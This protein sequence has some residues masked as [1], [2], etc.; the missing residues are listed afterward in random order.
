MLVLA[1]A[2]LAHP[3]QAQEP[4]PAEAPP[5]EGEELPILEM[6]QIAT[7]VEAAYPPEAEAA[8]IEGTVLLLV[9]IDETGAV[10]HVEVVQPIG[11]GFDEAALAA[12]QQMRFTPAMTAEGPVAVAFEFA[13]G[14]VLRPEAPAEAP[15]EAA[16]P[17]VNLEGSIREMGTRRWLEGAR[18]VVIGPEQ[19]EDLVAST[20][21]DGKFQI[22]GVPPGS[23]TLRVLNPG[24]VT[25]EQPIEVVEGEI[26]SANL[27][28]RAEEYRENEAVGVYRK[29]EQ[30][31]TRRTL[32]IE[33]VRR[34]PGTFGDPVKVI[35]TLPGAARSPFGTGLLII[36]GSNP[37][38]SGVYVDGVRIP[39]IYHITGTTSVLSPDLIEAVD[40]LPGGFG[41][42][43]GR[44]MGGVV[45]I[46]TKSEFDQDKIV[47]GTDILDSQIYFE[48]RLGKN[49]KHGFAVGAR[50]SY[51]DAFIPLFTADTGYVIKPRYWDY[52]VKWVPDLGAGRKFSTFVYG[53]N[54][55]LTVST[56]ED[57]A[58]GSDQDT[59]GDLF[60][61]YATH[62]LVVNFE[63]DLGN[64][65]QLRLTPS[66]G[67]DYADLGLGDEFRLKSTNL[68]PEL[69]AELPWKPSEAVEIVPGV[70]FIGGWWSFEF[71]SPFR[72][73]DVDDPLDERE[74]VF[75]DGHGTGWGPD[76]YIK[77]NLRPLE[78]RDKLLI[79]PG[80]R[81][82]L[83]RFT[84]KGSVTSDE[85]A[86]PYTIGAVD[87]RLLARWELVDNVVLKGS[88]GLYNQ[89][90]Q[91]SESIGVGTDV[92]T[93]FE[94]SWGSSIGIEHQLSQ[95]VH[96]D[97][98]LF[99]KQMD[100][101]IIFDE[102]WTGFGDAVFINEGA[103]RAWGTE[104]ILRH[105]K[106]KRF[107][108][109][110][111][112]TYS[113]SIRC[114]ASAEVCDEDGPDQQWYPFDF[115]QPH[116]FSAQGGYDLPLDFAVS[117]QVQYVSG[118]PDSVYNAGV[119]DADSDYYN[120][121]RIGE[122]NDER[123]PP[124]FQTS[125]RIDRLWTF[126]TWQ[127]A[128][129]VDLMNVVRGVNPE[130]TIYNYDYTDY[131][132]VRGLPFIPNIGIEARFY[133]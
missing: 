47:W 55:L 18:V 13:Y 60:T 84:Y 49:D 68:V 67:I 111:S 76:A 114:D 63:Q 30:E 58:Q 93:T 36:R 6:P 97:V 65:W 5:A 125:V 9:E 42:Q 16:P 40:Y 117:A 41:V 43:Y 127:L 44:S 46:R 103:G 53:F 106:T 19:P 12:A 113:R 29:D 110:V 37:E 118:N 124:F 14:F 8:G 54:D 74:N 57:V 126:R 89:P 11:N 22:R 99:Y 24:H 10:T 104:V 64:G 23:W 17:P 130:F 59:Q 62:R 3:V 101:L 51:I 31:V 81:T 120:P 82:N 73:G 25:L 15:T 91:P 26:T 88:T 56:P 35:Q 87:P 32:T 72:I 116:I 94:R 69:R 108:G 133:P 34:V 105:A 4:P 131:A 21:V 119:Y 128:T 95:A 85:G 27:W 33:E 129:Y 79:T 123:L 1:L 77:A 96:W 70:D 38:D 100:D 66:L 2:L 71:A 28:I 78:D 61:M 48:G 7:Y 92:V 107:F 132:Y 45:D 90:P 52:Q 122:Y 115:D 121:F 109:W 86:P 50:R 39:L 20:D 102:S 83:V 80:V 75:L 112:Y 98:D